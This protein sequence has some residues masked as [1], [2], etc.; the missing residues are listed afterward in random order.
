MEKGLYYLASPLKATPEEE[1]YR[2][3]VSLKLTTELLAQGI[4]VFSP[5][6][7]T[8]TIVEAIDFLSIEE[9]RRVIMAYLLDFLKVSKG[10]ILITIAG[11]RKSW[12]VQ[13]ELK[14]C[15]ENHIPVYT[16]ISDQIPKDIS[17][18]L[19]APLQQKQMDYYLESEEQGK[20]LSSISFK[21]KRVNL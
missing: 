6:I 18:I 14:F 8:R 19:S 15:Y 10:M 12:G 2:Y 16:I 3:E 5:L 9:R 4:H 1:A 11:W 20:Q 7:Y 21:Q 13:Q 17:T